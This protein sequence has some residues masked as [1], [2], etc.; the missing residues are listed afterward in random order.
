MTLMAKGNPNQMP[1]Y[2]KDRAERERFGNPSI[3]HPV[4]DR[5]P[6]IAQTRGEYVLEVYEKNLFLYMEARQAG[7]DFLAAIHTEG[8]DLLKAEIERE[9]ERGWRFVRQRLGPV[10]V[11]LH[12]GRRMLAPPGTRGFW[13]LNLGHGN[14]GLWWNEPPSKA[15]RAHGE[16]DDYTYC[17]LARAL[18]PTGEEYQEQPR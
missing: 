16:F 18:V 3:G 15:M 13:V 2:E 11:R 4:F 17:P 10:P 7:Q 1:L 5:H 6:D 12:D 9:V 8:L 14:M